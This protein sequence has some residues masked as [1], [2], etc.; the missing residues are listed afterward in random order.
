MVCF[1]EATKANYNGEWVKYNIAASSS[2]PEL[3]YRILF[4]EEFLSQSKQTKKPDEIYQRKGLS[5]VMGHNGIYFLSVVTY[6]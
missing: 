4:Q 3:T 5:S 2:L 6:M 1:W